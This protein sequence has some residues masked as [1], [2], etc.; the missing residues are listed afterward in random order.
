MYV[1]YGN[2]TVLTMETLLQSG[3]GTCEQ[4][5][6]DTVSEVDV[7]LSA[8]EDE[9]VL[10]L[11]W[12]ARSRA[13]RGR[14]QVGSSEARRV[15]TRQTEEELD[16]VAEAVEGERRLLHVA[17]GNLHSTEHLTALISHRLQHALHCARRS[18]RLRVLL[19]CTRCR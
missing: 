10:W 15:R 12:Q 4:A 14:R 1:N 17:E 5:G 7:S 3:D 2:L 19:C 6:V 16:Q 18:S 13:G 11:E 9:R 8:G